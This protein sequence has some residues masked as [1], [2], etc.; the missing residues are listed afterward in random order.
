[1]FFV[2]YLFII[3]FLASV[4]LGLLL[5]AL[6]IKKSEKT[7]IPEIIGSD[8]LLVTLSATFICFVSWLMILFV[9]IFVNCNGD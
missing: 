6:I 7:P 5:Y 8:T 4:V 1:M 3:L 2:L 9:C